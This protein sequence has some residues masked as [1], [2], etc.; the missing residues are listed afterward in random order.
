M[1]R[2]LGQDKKTIMSI[3]KSLKYRII[4]KNFLLF[5]FAFFFSFAVVSAQVVILDFEE[6]GT[7]TTF[8]YFGSDLEPDVGATEVIA[9]P[10]PSGINTSAMVSNFMTLA[11]GQVWQGAYSN[12]NPSIPVNLVTATEICLDVWVP[13]ATLL[14]LKLENGNLANWITTQDIT[15]TNTWTEVCFD[16]SAPSIEDPMEVAVGGV[17]STVV[18]FFDFNI[19]NVDATYYFDNLEI[20]G[21]SSEPVDVTLSVDMNNYVGDFTTVFLS[22]T[23]N[24]WSADSN[25][26]TDDDADGVWTT[27]VN[28][29]PGSYEYKFQL[30]GW[31]N[32]EQFN[33]YESCTVTD[34]SGEFHN[35]SLVVALEETL[36]TVC[37]NSCYACGEGVM[38]T[39]NLGEG[40]TVVDDSGLFIAGGGNFGTPGDYPLSDNG[41]GTW[42]LTI[43]REVGFTSYFTFTNGACADW[44]CKENVAGQDCA[45]PDNFND[46]SMG[47]IMQDT[48]IATCFG[49]CTTTTDC[50]DPGAGDITFM[51]DMNSYAGSF[52]TAYVT[53]TFAGWSGDAHPMTDD[54]ADGVWTTTI[55]LS[56]G[57]IEYKFEVDNW[58]DQEL[59]TEGDPCTVTNG[60]FTNRTLTVDGDQ[61]V[62]FIWG[63]CDGCTVGLNDIAV[64][65][66]IFK[67]QPTLVKSETTLIFGDTYTAAKE[68]SVFNALGQM[69]AE[70]KV[71]AGITQYILDVN[72]FE[73]GLYF[74][75]VTTEAKQQT[76]KII[77]NR[78]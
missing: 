29:D 42:S 59:F 9:N 34:P 49:M 24:D 70:V 76:Q 28:L 62:C 5:T 54:D 46:R 60:G 11:S 8:S 2:Y 31:A 16:I 51:V 10:D 17:Y 64:D 73:D 15:E 43:E 75:N 45:N 25:P 22:G 12:P 7:S 71:E 50:S 21:G 74:I 36:P 67:V 27:T 20:I 38:I 77:V 56:S 72:N 63:T 19:D 41:D 37:F 52:T 65:N 18:F 58:T 40:S 30:D 53:G 69:V 57:P 6:A 48:I 3:L 68:L 61:E 14:A 44:A 78:N 55:P 33:G 35:R 13:Q 26:L 66:A 47:P 23:F 4:M 1:K 39:I 32:Q